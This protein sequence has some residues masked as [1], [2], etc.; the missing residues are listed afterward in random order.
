M[1][2]MLT[3]IIGD[4]PNIWTSETLAGPVKPG[5]DTLSRI[6]V[7]LIYMATLSLKRNR[8]ICY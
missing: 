8:W 3:S 4:T 1:D 5:A 7:D 6:G 2:E